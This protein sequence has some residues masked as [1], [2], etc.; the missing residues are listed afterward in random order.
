VSRLAW[1]WP[2]PA[3]EAADPQSPT[4]RRARAHAATREVLADRRR[5]E[6]QAVEQLLGRLRQLKRDLQAVILDHA[7]PFRRFVVSTLIEEV[8]RL[9]AAAHRDLTGSVEPTLRRAQR[10]GAAAAD[11]PLRAAQIAITAIPGLDPT[12]VTQAAELTADLLSEPMQQ[13]RTSVVTRVRRAAV[14]GET[15]HQ[16]MQALA[17]QIGA[18]GFDAAAFRAERIVRT[19]LSRVFNAS[20]Y[21]RLASLADQFPFLRK[22]WLDS[23]DSRVRLGHREAGRRYARGQG[24]PIRER[25]R[26]PVYRES[27]RRAPVLLGY[28]ELR[29]PVDPA[30]EPS[31]R[32]AAAATIMC[33]CVGVV[34]FDPTQLVAPART[35]VGLAEPAA[36]VPE[37]T[38]AVPRRAPRPPKL[39]PGA[40]VRERVLALHQRLRAR[41]EAA[42]E[43]SDK[44]V[45]AY[46][47]A[48]RAELA[49]GP[50]DPRY[51]ELKERADVAAR[52]LDAALQRVS[53]LREQ[54]RT[55]LLAAL[56]VP[57]ALR[58]PIPLTL[59]RAI[60]SDPR[61]AVVRDAARQLERWVAG[62]NF[63]A[64]VRVEATRRGRSYA[65]SDTNAVYLAHDTARMMA[66]HE[67]GHILEF[68]T[69]QV[70]QAARAFLERRTAGEKPQRLSV[71]MPEYVFGRNEV[72]KP[73]RFMAPYAGKIY[74]SGW[75]EIVS[76][77]VQWLYDDPVRLAREDPEYFA[78][79]VDVLRGR[80]GQ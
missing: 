57:P 12:L 61:A 40:D 7:T 64:V 44:A 6:R 38:P 47:A 32:L 23:R 79:I 69:P 9:I 25:F 10:L 41:L 70:H 73:D 51:P 56:S 37:P 33:R 36:V 27:P 17:A 31:G 65:R 39:R 68:N 62:G 59:S 63:G 29:F 54:L 35:T 24:V 43:V 50:D 16:Q 20:T 71:L 5:L 42:Q 80:S 28:A 67:L 26:V 78:F 19:E 48:W 1:P 22:A 60:A 14:L 76:V 58:R 74:E 13:F 46:R 34:D 77:G 52:A 55:R 4:R 2:A 72:A 15:A 49:A 21:D 53:R 11:E 66:A 75:T 3:W 18:A 45:D 30:A 8:D